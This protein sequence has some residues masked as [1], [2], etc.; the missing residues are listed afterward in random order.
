VAKS[1]A[2]SCPL[3]L[4]VNDPVDMLAVTMLHSTPPQSA[5]LYLC[6]LCV[7]EVMKAGIQSDLIDPSEVFPDAAA[8][9]NPARNPGDNPPAD[10]A[11]DSLV[12]QDSAD[13]ERPGEH[14]PEP[15]VSAGGEG[16]TDDKARTD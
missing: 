4:S 14:R 15:E 11:A 2:M 1:I 12:L 13:G 6:R 3:C 5:P 9:A 10:S 16:T 7:L 8:G